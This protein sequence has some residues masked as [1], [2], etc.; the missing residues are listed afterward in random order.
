M[1]MNEKIIIKINNLTQSERA[2]YNLYLD[3]MKS[4]NNDESLFTYDL[5]MDSIC[6]LSDQ[7]IQVIMAS[8]YKQ[9]LISK[10]VFNV[11]NFKQKASTS[12]KETKTTNV[13]K[14]VEVEKQESKEKDSGVCKNND[15]IISNLNNFIKFQEDFQDFFKE[16]KIEINKEEEISEYK[17]QISNL[18]NENKKD[19]KM[20][21]DLKD[22][23]EQS[24]KIILNNNDEYQKV[25]QSLKE[26]QQKSKEI[27]KKFNTLKQEYANLKNMQTEHFEVT[28]AVI[29]NTLAQ[30]MQIPNWQ[31]DNTMK[32]KFQKEIMDAYSQL[33]KDV[34]K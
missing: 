3:L 9:G 6:D 16:L 11:I 5:L 8:L 25:I 19:I 21:N 12:L 22:N 33:M 27:E 10:R 13:V 32:A 31:M 20:I 24:R 28:Y 14:K 7:E 26:E 17:N 29:S 23:L 34:L 2:T 15:L 18:L 1:E 30:Y 4:I